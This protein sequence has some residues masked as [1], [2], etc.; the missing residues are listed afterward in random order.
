MVIVYNFCYSTTELIG[1]RKD[2]ICIQRADFFVGK[3]EIY[4]RMSEKSSTFAAAKVLQPK[5]TSAKR[6]AIT[7]LIITEL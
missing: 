6:C 5:I 1:K 2:I 3:S 4:L 7:Y